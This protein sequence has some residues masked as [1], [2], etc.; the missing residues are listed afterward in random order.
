MTMMYL[1]FVAQDCGGELMPDLQGVWHV[2]STPTAALEWCVMQMAWRGRRAEGFVFEVEAFRPGIRDALSNAGGMAWWKSSEIRCGWG[3]D[4]DVR[5]FWRDGDV[6]FE[7]T[8][9]DGMV[10]FAKIH[11]GNAG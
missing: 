10:E 9:E 4:G 3:T 1:A 7:N 6:L 5:R 2:A 11:Q 8:D